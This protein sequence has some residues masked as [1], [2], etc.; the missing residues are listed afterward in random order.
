M[1]HAFSRLTKYL[2][3]DADKMIAG[4][5]SV[6]V[7]QLFF[8]EILN[9]G[10]AWATA[11]HLDSKDTACASVHSSLK[12]FAR[13]TGLNFLALDDPSILKMIPAPRRA[14]AEPSASATI[15]VAAQAHLEH[16]AKFHPSPR[17]RHY[18]GCAALCGILSLCGVE[19]L[20]CR[21]MSFPE[22]VLGDVSSM[23]WLRC[24]AG[25]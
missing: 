22:F 20:R 19:I 23:L 21:F 15:A 2:G 1:R 13:Y 9:Q 11:R 12:T 8:N 4:G 3:A 10:R 24:M 17:V 6:V 14:E 18:A 7:L 25:K 5:L 16:L